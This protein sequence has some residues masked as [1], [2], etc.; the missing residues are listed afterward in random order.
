MHAHGLNSLWSCKHT[1]HITESVEVLF[2]ITKLCCSSFHPP[3]CNMKFSWRSALPA[4][5]WQG[6]LFF[7]FFTVLHVSHA[8]PVSLHL[9]DRAFILFEWKKVQTRADLMEHSRGGVLDYFLQECSWQTRKKGPACFNCSFPRTFCSEK[10]CYLLARRIPGS[11]FPLGAL[12]SSCSP[13]KS[14]LGE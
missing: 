3:A 12:A 11:G 5:S 9:N 8:G 2:V 13:N 14:R 7:F 10:R 4:L 6:L 1:R